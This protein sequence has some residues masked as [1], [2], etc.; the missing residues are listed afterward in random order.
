MRGTTEPPTGTEL[1]TTLRTTTGFV[2]VEEHWVVVQAPSVMVAV[3]V[4]VVESVGLTT[5]P[6]VAVAESP[7][8]SVTVM[9]SFEPVTFTVH[10]S[11]EV[12]VVQVGVPESVTFDGSGSVT[13]AGPEAVPVF[14]TTTE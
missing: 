10:V 12:T 1:F 8:A 7:L 9:T 2:T 6:N 11:G 13:V 14:F 4:T 3:F 5:A